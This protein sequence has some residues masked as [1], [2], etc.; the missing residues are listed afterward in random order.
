[1]LTNLETVRN[2]LEKTGIKTYDWN[3]DPRIKEKIKLLATNEYQSGGSDK[4]LD[5]IKNMS[6]EQ[7]QIWLS[8]IIVKDMGLGVKI[9]NNSEEK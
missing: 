9:I 1:M 6:P 2:N 3:D 5:I 4:V 7:L 8:E